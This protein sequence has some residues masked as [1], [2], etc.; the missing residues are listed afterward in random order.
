M[1]TLEEY[2]AKV[3]KIVYAET[4]LG[5]ERL[6]YDDQE[7]DSIVAKFEDHEVVF[8]SNNTLMLTKNFYPTSVRKLSDLL[9]Y[10]KTHEVK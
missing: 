10:I 5:L 3:S 7:P 2:Y 8:Y 4:G 1:K 6:P 9:T